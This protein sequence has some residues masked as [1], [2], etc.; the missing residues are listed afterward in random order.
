M[1]VLSTPRHALF[2]LTLVAS[3][4]AACG[5][6]RSSPPALNDEERLRADLAIPADVALASLR[7]TPGAGGTFGREGLRIV[8]TFKLTPAQL[9]AYRAHAAAAPEWAPLPLP[10]DVDG[11]REPPIEVSAAGAK[12]WG[13]CRVS[14][15][16]TG[17]PWEHLPCA[18]AR[19]R[20]DQYR[21]AVL[22]EDAAEI[23]VV[24]KNYY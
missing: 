11:F 22:D 23:V 6:K 14:I 21:I 7:T 18:K 13:F 24:Y 9:G 20:F 4:L 19:F 10:A 12:G 3:L 17:A 2:G 8:A 16:H 5:S 15:Y 1:T